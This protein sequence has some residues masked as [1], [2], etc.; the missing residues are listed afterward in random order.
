MMTLSQLMVGRLLYV[1]APIQIANVGL[2]VAIRYG[3]VRKQF[4]PKGG[5]ETN[6]LDYSSHKKKLMPAIA[7]NL[8]LEFTRNQLILMLKGK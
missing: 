8:A 7:T 4:G 1:I 3:S 2:R 6:I 5:V